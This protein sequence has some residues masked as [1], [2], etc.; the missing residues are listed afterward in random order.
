[1]ATIV[2]QEPGVPAPSAS[3]NVAIKAE[4]P[5]A[6]VGIKSDNP[7]EDDALYEDAGDLDMTHGTRGIWLVKLPKFLLESWSQLDLDE[8]ITIGEIMVSSDERFRLKLSDGLEVHNELPTQYDMVLNNRQVTNTWVFTEKDMPGFDPSGGAGAGA[9]AGGKKATVVQQEG[10]PSMPARLLYGEKPKQSFADRNK[11]GG[12]G[13]KKGQSGGGQP[14]YMR[15]AIPKK[16]A[17]VGTVVH[18]A[19]VMTPENDAKY[20]KLMMEAQRKAIQPKKIMQ[21]LSGPVGGNLLAPGTMGA[22]TGNFD[23]FIVRDVFFPSLFFLSN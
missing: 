12:G 21:V 14:P 6:S 4:H 20:K 1:M 15:K 10:M 17:L 5:D 23:S 22:S 13:W 9:G 11:G 7:A 3:N 2:K 19:T 8:E 16:T 18:E